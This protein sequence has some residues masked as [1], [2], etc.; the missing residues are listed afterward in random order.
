MRERE[1]ERER[2]RERES[3]RGRETERERVREGERERLKLKT[4]EEM[5]RVWDE[6]KLP[7]IYSRLFI[8]RKIYSRNRGYLFTVSTEIR[9]L[10]SVR[11]VLDIQC[12]EEIFEKKS[13]N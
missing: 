1:W 3:E 11:T 9:D 2:E 12:N 13:K 7:K 4:A 5:D 10:F 8:S 6:I